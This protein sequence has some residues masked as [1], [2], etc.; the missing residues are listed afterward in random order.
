VNK[1]GV[2]MIQEKDC[3]SLSSQDA[4]M[5]TLPCI[6]DSFERCSR[7]QAMSDIQLRSG[8]ASTFFMG[9]KKFSADAPANHHVKK[10]VQRCRCL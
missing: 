9:G 10:Q 4:F 5:T 7:C 3:S 1:K 6:D 2:W 8:A